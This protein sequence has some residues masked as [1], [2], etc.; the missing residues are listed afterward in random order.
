MT[1]FIN[2]GYTDTFRHFYPEE[3]K[4]SGGVIGL[5]L[6]QKMWMEIRLFF[7][8]PRRFGHDQR[9]LYFK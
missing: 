1:N 4:Y 6:E 5:T 7:G 9:C 8:Q 2:A 3:I